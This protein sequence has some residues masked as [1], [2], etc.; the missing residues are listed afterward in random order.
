MWNPTRSAAAQLAEP[1]AEVD[2]DRFNR[3]LSVDLAKDRA[4][5]VVMDG[6]TYET[7]KKAATLPDTDITIDGRRG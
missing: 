7:R 5:I 3:G 2:L 6:A 4:S 1:A